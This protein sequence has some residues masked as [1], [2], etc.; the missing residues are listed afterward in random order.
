MRGRTPEEA[1]TDLVDG[2][3]LAD[4]AVRKKLAEG[5]NAAIEQCDDPMIKLALAVDADA[6]AVRK[7]REDKVEGVQDAQYALIAKAQRSTGK[8]D[9]IYPDA[10]FTLRLAFGAVKGYEIDGNDYPRYTTIGGAFA[11]RRR[12]SRQRRLTSCRRAGIEAKAGTT[13]ISTPR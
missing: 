11:A 2:S 10:T 7:V 12:A 8:G 6:R 4:V 13:R 3:K 9:S 5:G 1:A